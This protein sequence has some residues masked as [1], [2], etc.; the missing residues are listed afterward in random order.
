MRTVL[1]TDSFYPAVDGTTTTVRNI[2]DRLVDRGDEVLIVAPGPGL[3][4]Y[5]GQQVARVRPLDKP[6]RQV[7]DALA[8]FGPDLVH[9][10]SP[11]TLGR[12]ALKHARRRDVA[13]VV[14]Q[15]SP[16]T[17]VAAPLWQAKV[18]G[19]ADR[20]VVTSPWMQERL[21]A[22][23][24]T[25]TLWTPGVDT[26]AFTPALRDPWLH[27]RW[28]RARSRG[29][30]RVVV[31][32]VG[33]LEKRN[34]VRRLAALGHVPGTRVVVVGEGSQRGWLAAHVPGVRLTGPLRG[35][36]LA[37]ALASFDVL[38]HPGRS[39]TCA[40]VLRE[41]AAS[42]VP[43]VAVRAGGA[44][45]AVAHL[46][47]GLL[48]D[49]DDAHGLR[50]AVAAIAADR[51]RGLLGEHG[52]RLATARDWTRAVDE[53]LAEHHAPVLGTSATAPDPGVRA[54]A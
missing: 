28:A 35:G 48:V 32:F 2:A 38:V 1:V 7:R 54:S 47:S 17:D 13:T 45:D 31:G 52:R 22:L 44:P 37:T 6:G 27:G 53:L 46:E 30:P 11:G 36:D 51:H 23:G 33:A 4:S 21:D 19:R 3:T 41:A 26:A 9:V 34:D 8:A 5:R 24:T 18:A 43:V 25:A 15:Q 39:L 16:L 14:V 12:K 20:V 10:T 42:A 49:P 40:H 29:G 50:R